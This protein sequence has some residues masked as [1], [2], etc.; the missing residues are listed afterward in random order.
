[1]R[2]L[3]LR[4]LATAKEGFGCLALRSMWEDNLKPLA[5]RSKFQR[6]RIQNTPNF[7]IIVILE[8]HKEL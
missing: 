2:A 6:L 8:Q 3:V 7:S 1:M 5:S 4:S